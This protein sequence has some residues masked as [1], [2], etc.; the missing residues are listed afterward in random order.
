MS[1][2]AEGKIGIVLALLALG[3]NG[4]LYV[5]SHPYAD[6]VSWSVIAILALGFVLVAA[7]HFKIKIDRG[8]DRPSYCHDCARTKYF[9]A[10][11]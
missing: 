11:F 9:Q 7:Q 5:F 1:L 6:I 10:L 3:V 2:S 8:T 4:A